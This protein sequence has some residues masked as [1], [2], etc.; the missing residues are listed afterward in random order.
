MIDS[1]L[2][3]GEKIS[4]I[5]KIDEISGYNNDLDDIAKN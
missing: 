4:I 2:F 1:V 5:E 3:V